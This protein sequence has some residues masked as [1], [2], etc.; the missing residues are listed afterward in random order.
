[1][2]FDYKK[3]SLENLENW[4]HDAISCSEATPKEIYDVI[5]E[6]VRENYYT[7]KHCT[8]RCSELLELLNGHRPVNFDNLYDDG[9]TSWQY[10]DNNFVVNKN[11]NLYPKDK[12][13][14]WSL[15]VQVDGLSGE[16]YV[17][18]PDDLLEAANLKEGDQVEWIDCG[19]GSFELR[20]VNGIK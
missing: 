15:P 4:L 20:K 19:N 11:G 7:Y 8:S 6:V 18:F 14:K 2:D 16:C 9:D 3:Y 5:K 12:V 10:V 1:M 17:E 13:M